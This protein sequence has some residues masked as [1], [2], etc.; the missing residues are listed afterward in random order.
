VLVVDDDADVRHLV[1][2]VLS[3]ETIE[4][5]EAGSGSEALHALEDG[6]VDGLVLDWMMPGMNGLE[7]LRRVRE[8]PDLA[9]VKIVMLTAMDDDRL[10]DAVEAGADWIVKKP[11]DTE[12]L[13]E[14]LST[15]LPKEPVAATPRRQRPRGLQTWS[16]LQG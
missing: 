1:R 3:T 6:H 13:L 12:N 15:L 8:D 5:V 9:D 11:F 16:D 4:V 14:A 7:V 10:I 2:I